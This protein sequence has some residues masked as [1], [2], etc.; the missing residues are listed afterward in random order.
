VRK[1]RRGPKRHAIPSKRQDPLV[2]AMLNP[3][4]VTQGFR[5]FVV[6]QLSEVG[7]IV[8]KPMFGGVGLYCDGVFFGVIARDTL[9]LKVGDLNRG[10]FERAGMT[11]F[12]P[13][14]RRRGR[15]YQAVPVAV[16]ESAAE[17]AA[18]ARKAIQMARSD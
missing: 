14:P 10:D 4:A 13:D 2:D 12:T 18:W 3:R 11:V 1:G 17:L 9:Y 6:D 5:C 16:L 8:A 15:K 7:E